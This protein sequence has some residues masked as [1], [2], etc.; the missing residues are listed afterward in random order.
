M[1]RA[2]AGRDGVGRERGMREMGEDRERGRAV[3]NQTM[4]GLLCYMKEMELNPAN[5]E[6][7]WK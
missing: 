2:G 7:S 6:M 3:R 1:G 5:D 4:K